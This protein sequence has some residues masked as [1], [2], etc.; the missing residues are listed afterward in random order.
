MDYQ[1]TT[2]CCH[3]FIICYKHPRRCSFWT[4]SIIYIFDGRELCLLE[5]VGNPVWSAALIERLVGW[6]VI[7][8]Q[9]VMEIWTLVEWQV[10]QRECF[11][12]SNN[13]TWYI[14][15]Y[16]K[17]NHMKYLTQI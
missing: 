16:L 5:K 13:I 12:K 7:F 3:D 14:L 17:S 8:T 11:K 2:S 10:I 9:L 15:A 1:L 4:L 6:R